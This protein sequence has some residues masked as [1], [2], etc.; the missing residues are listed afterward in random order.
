MISIGRFNDILTLAS[1]SRIT[2]I[3]SYLI[4]KK[5]ILLISYHVTEPILTFFVLYFIFPKTNRSTNWASD[6]SI[7]F[8]GTT[9]VRQGN[10]S[11]Q[12]IIIL[13]IWVYG[14]KKITY[15]IIVIIMCSGIPALVYLNLFTTTDYFNNIW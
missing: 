3:I 1:L 8:C 13:I 4:T 10:C 11:A 12:S 5:I 7:L 6:I 9:Y 2:S 15:Y 14:G